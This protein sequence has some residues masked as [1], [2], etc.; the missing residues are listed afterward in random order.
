M[1]SIVLQSLSELVIDNLKN[2][3]PD[4][5]V[6]F[7]SLGTEVQGK[8]VVNIV[9]ENPYS[10]RAIKKTAE[11]ISNKIVLWISE[12]ENKKIKRIN[13]YD[14]A[15]KKLISNLDNHNA[16]IVYSNFVE[17]DCATR[18]KSK[19][20]LIPYQLG[21]IRDDFDFGFVMILN[22]ELIK[23][24]ASEM[25]EN[26]LYSGFYDMRLR[27]SEV[28]NLIHIDEYLY[29]ADVEYRKDDMEEH[30]K[31][32]ASNRR[33]LQ[34]EYEKVATEHLKRI[35]AYITPTKKLFDFKKVEESFPVEASVIIP[36]KNRAKTIEAAV[37][38]ALNQKTDFEFN[39]IV[40]D[41]YSDDGTTD[42][43]KQIAAT[44]QKLIHLIPEEKNLQ[45]GGCWNYA[46]R[47]SYCGRFAVQ[48]DSDDLYY[49]KYALAKIM[50]KFYEDGS[51]MVI[52]SYKLTDFNL[53]EI[54]PGIVDHREW[55]DQNGVNNALRINGL[56]A[57]R[58]FYTSVL[59]KIEIPNVSYGEDY[60]LG[61]TIS[62]TY[63][64]SRIY[65]PIYICR[66][67]A[68]NSD[69]DLSQE[70]INNNNYYKDSLRTKEIIERQK[71]NKYAGE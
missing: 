61:I 13:F 9:D 28:S 5:M 32:V 47:S 53:N 35:G 50:K 55:T 24:I 59:R 48:L 52:G 4:G 40:V 14:E 66:R 2:N 38:S 8:N 18:K 45:I 27:I 70:K 6:E 57:P 12:Y 44:N 29:S 39:V 26:Y 33:T 63:K 20:P 1:V 31:Y 49:D 46:V 64:I 17:Y 71:L 7:I 65:E 21:S 11:A 10:S 23:S 68:G 51:A 67:W 15:L 58:A 19:H 30:F 42:I 36:V 37:N 16:G 56:G 25:E 22:G 69:A 34:L 54:P 62:R 3:F 41:N 43:L 60:Y